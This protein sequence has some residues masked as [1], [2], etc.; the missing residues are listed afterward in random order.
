MRGGARNESVCT[1][2]RRIRSLLVCCDPE[3]APALLAALAGAGIAGAEI[4]EL[5]EEG[6]GVVALARGLPAPWPHFATD[7]A[8][9]ITGHTLLVDGGW[10]A[11]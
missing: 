11:R 4:G 9:Y 6:A 3:E 2:H 1:C 5:T 7:E 8:A 10:R